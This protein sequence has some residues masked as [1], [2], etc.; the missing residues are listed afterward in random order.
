MLKFFLDRPKTKKGDDALVAEMQRL[1]TILQAR[2][3]LKEIRPNALPAKLRHAPNVTGDVSLLTSSLSGWI[4][5]EKFSRVAEGVGF[6]D[7]RGADMI[8][9]ALRYRERTVA[10]LWLVAI[11]LAT[12]TRAYTTLGKTVG[13]AG[14]TGPVNVAGEIEIDYPTEDKIES[15]SLIDVLNGEVRSK[16]LAGRVVILGADLK[17]VPKVRTKLGPIGAHRAFWHGLMGVWAKL[18]P[19]EL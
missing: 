5:L 14:K 7:A 1:P 16:D 10:S 6:V 4:P 18:K 8:P 3:D 19:A 11:E 9:L 2:F 13:I 12:G 15:H 17:D